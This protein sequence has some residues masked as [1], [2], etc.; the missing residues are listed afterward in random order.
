MAEFDHSKC[1]AADPFAGDFGDSGDKTLSDKI[2]KAAKDHEAACHDCGGDIKKGEMHRSRTD[3]FV[4]D[5]MMSF[6]WCS[7]CC[8]AMAIAGEDSGKAWEARIGLHR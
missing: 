3:V 6:R 7:A 5:G 2:V 1:L 8:H 4:G